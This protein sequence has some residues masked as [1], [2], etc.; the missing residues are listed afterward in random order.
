M[1]SLEEQNILTNFYLKLEEINEYIP[2]IHPSIPDWD[3]TSSDLRLKIW[4]ESNALVHLNPEHI[5]EKFNDSKDLVI[6]YLYERL[7]NTQNNLLAGKY[8]YFL[9]CLTKNNQYG[10]KAIDE[11]QKTLYSYL[12]GPIKENTFL[13]FKDIF[14]IIIKLTESTKYKTEELKEQ[15]HNF[16]K[17]PG[18]QGRIKTSIIEL[19]SKTRLFKIKD[20]DYVPELCCALAN[21]ESKHRFI[22]INL[23]L[24]LEIA[25]RLQD[26]AIQKSIYELLGDNEYK[27]IKPY[28]GKP[29]SL[30]I[31]LQNRSIYKKIIQYYKNAHTKE[32]H[33]HAIL[34]YNSN[35]RNCKL[36]KVQVNV[37]IKNKEEKQKV[38]DELFF[39]IVNTSTEE[40]CNQLIFGNKL[41]LIPDEYLEKHAKEYNDGILFQSLTPS[42]ID[43]NN[44]EKNENVKEYLRF[45]L[46]KES[47]QITSNFTFHV[48]MECFSKNRISYN[49]IAKE[50][51]NNTYFGKEIKFIRNGQ[52]LS[53]T[54]FTMIDI[55][56]KSFCQQYN[57][58]FKN[59]QPDWRISI[60]LLSLKFEGILR[61]IVDLS[62]GV[63]TK[64]DNEGNTTDK[65]LDDLL[66]SPEINN[67]FNKDDINLFQ[68]TF[69]NKGFNIR[70]YVAHSFYKPQDYDWSK[71]ILV[72]LCVLR[73]AKFQ[74]IEIQNQEPLPRSVPS[75]T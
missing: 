1:L 60:D 71:A 74:F 68:Y 35:K 64:V 7:K 56:L 69:T 72:F 40:I 73:L 48:I 6:E 53:Y 57:L 17:D 39:S 63:I 26:P 28:D 52:E 23:E 62:G 21:K 31:P 24:G 36:P 34:E 58:I 51:C 33:N 44:N 22:E 66:R 14:E 38:L 41:L 29:E 32:K 9:Y 18:I 8:N 55:G 50:L 65:L 49:K 67:I 13:K 45:N 10:N 37:K 47:I 46:Y 4:I 11:F 27:R 19:I 43:I 16:L 59:K 61:D 20:L 12:N 25:K 30:I 2:L 54:W 75:Q 5:R 42:S 15:T 3:K 70:N